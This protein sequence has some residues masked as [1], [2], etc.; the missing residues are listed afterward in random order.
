MIVSTHHELEEL[1]NGTYRHI[2]HVRRIAHYKSGSLVH[3]VNIWAAGDIAYPY[4][5]LVSSLGV[6][7]ASDGARRF[8]PLPDDD[9]T[10]IEVETPYIKPVTTWEKTNL[11]TLSAVS[12]TLGAQTMSLKTS[13]VHA[14][15]YCKAEYEL[16]GGY[17]PPGSQLAFPYT[18]SGLTRTGD[19]FS[20]ARGVK[21]VQLRPPT[22]YDAASP[23]NTLPIGYSWENLDG[24]ECLLF[25]LPDLRGMAKPVIDPT[26]V[27][28]PDAADEVDC[29]LDSGSPA[30]NS[31]TSTFCYIG[32]SGV[33]TL[34]QLIKFS[35]ATVPDS[36]TSAVL[37][38]YCLTDSSS[39]ARTF[40]VFRQK[41]AW[42]ETAN[43]NKYNAVDNW[44]TSGGFGANDCEQTEI[45]SR[46]F[47]AAETVNEFKNFN[48]TPMTK[49][50]LDLGNGW[51]MKADTENADLYQ[52]AS[53]DHITAAYRPT[54]TVT[55]TLGGSGIFQS[56]IF[57]SPIFGGSVVR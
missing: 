46:D 39:N 23:T 29:W 3:D 12:N 7:V 5:A 42:I 6:L 10:W 32:Q 57:D 36:F 26:I 47:T 27:L 51:M 19:I 34:R 21:V 15:H 16:L 43:W 53:S 18:L 55:Y 56:A 31:S 9:R 8:C 30:F 20:D 28:Q 45:G 22:V 38:L 35:L 54:L 37:G 33:E 25:R 52:F 17:L 13:I 40:R 24:R 48:L 4:Q 2:Q 44:Q 1:G 14:G 50:G 11:G 41:R 49:V